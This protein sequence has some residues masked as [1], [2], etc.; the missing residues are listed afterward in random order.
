MLKLKAEE[1]GIYSDN[2]QVSSQQIEEYVKQ[3][4]IKFSETPN[5]QQV[6]DESPVKKG[7]SLIT[8]KQNSSNSASGH[9]P[10]MQSDSQPPLR[11]HTTQGA[12]RRKVN[13][14]EIV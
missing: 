12:A 1:K 14:G 8:N 11:M 13:I 5:A 6:F 7:R 3:H 2:D 4:Q 9:Y 10:R